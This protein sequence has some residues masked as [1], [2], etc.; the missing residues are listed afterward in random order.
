[1]PTISDL[2]PGDAAGRGATLLEVAGLT[3]HAGCFEDWI[4]TTDERATVR[5]SAGL[6]PFSISGDRSDNTSF[7]VPH[8]TGTDVV[9]LRASGNEIRSAHF[10]VVAENGTVVSGFATVETNDVTTAPS[11]CTFA[12]SA[13]SS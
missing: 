3:F 4:G 11:D 9:V 5:V 7:N 13:I 1:M 8:T 6:S 10:T 2:V 12:F